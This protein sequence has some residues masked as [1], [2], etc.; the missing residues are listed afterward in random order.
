MTNIIATDFQKLEVDSPLVSLFEVSIPGT[1]PLY[2]H[3]GVEGDFS[4]VQFRDATNNAQINEY[5]AMPMIV[6]GLEMN[7]DG[8][9]ARPRLTVA[10]IGANLTTRLG[11]VKF[12]DLIGQ[13]VTRRQ[14]LQKYLYGET[15]DA[16]PPVELTRQ[17]FIIDRITNENP[18]SVEFELAVAYDLEGVRLPRRRVV[19][20]FCSWMYQGYDLYEKGG[21]T[22]SKD[23]TRKVFDGT[24]LRTHNFY[25]TRDDNPLIPDSVTPSD[26]S[27]S[28]TYTTSSMVKKVG[29]DEYY[30]SLFDGNQ[31]NALTTGFWKQ[32]YRYGNYS[33]STVYT[34]GKFVK[35]TITVN[36][37]TITTIWE[38]LVSP[39]VAGK[40]PALNSVYWR[41]ADSCGKT[42]NSCK[43]RF[44]GTPIDATSAGSTPSGKKDTT[45]VLPFGAFPGTTK[46]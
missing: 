9:S 41:R 36:S 20:K 32:V 10:N 27:S 21:C 11:S 38:C 14:T 25:F 30:L 28:T 45:Q 2:L 31:G 7:S 22:W 5:F 46:F 33:A 1:T 12:S 37:K 29:V 3:P 34:V 26:Y 17:T 24:T 40:T 23:G 43:C 8:A 13:R 6:D 15:G 18:I 16:S 4:T 39:G 42:L 44:Q 19:G 35:H